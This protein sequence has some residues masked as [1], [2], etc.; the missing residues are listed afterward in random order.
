MYSS[1]LPSSDWIVWRPAFCSFP[2]SLRIPTIHCCLSP[3]WM[4]LFVCSRD[5]SDWAQSHITGSVFIR[6][7][8]HP[9]MRHYRWAS[10]APSPMNS[11][12]FVVQ[13]SRCGFSRFVDSI[14]DCADINLSQ[15]DQ[16]HGGN[17]ERTRGSTTGA[18]CATRL[19]LQP[20][21]PSSAAHNL[22]P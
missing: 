4:Q 5:A 18:I 20:A 11:S 13:N 22:C 19:S 10:S 3:L 12:S 6:F 15:L 21:R 7:H 16:A 1:L 14:A 8:T 2:L 17:C 9:P